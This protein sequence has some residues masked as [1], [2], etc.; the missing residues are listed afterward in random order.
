MKISA[1]GKGGRGRKNLPGVG[2]PP[3][4]FFFS[5]Q[6]EGALPDLQTLLFS[7]GEIGTWI[8]AHPDNTFTTHSGAMI[9]ASAG[10]T[11]GLALDKSQQLGPEIITPA[12]GPYSAIPA[13]IS[14]SGIAS[15]ELIG[16][17]VRATINS[18]TASQRMEI[19]FTAIVGKSYRLVGT[20]DSNF[21]FMPS[22]FVGAN[23]STYAFQSAGPQ[24]QHVIFTA[25]ATSVVLR[26]YIRTSAGAAGSQQSG[27]YVEFSDMS[28]REIAGN[29][30]SQ[31]TVAARPILERVTVAGQ[32]DNWYLF[33]DAVDDTLNWTAPAADYTVAY[34]TTGGVVTILEN[35]ALSGATD[36]LQA[37]HTG[38]YIAVNRLLTPLEKAKVSLYLATRWSGI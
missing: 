36:I 2:S 31:A 38:A 37:A 9:G 12:A 13:G 22:S 33:D 4:H 15:I 30:A 28:I 20:F 32:P 18:P 6:R 27:D 17:R 14:A 11:V 5:G 3:Y 26:F 1:R 7:N 10:T 24:N 29:H 21:G 23:P 35:Q 34:V 16:G 8:E 25:T 19:A